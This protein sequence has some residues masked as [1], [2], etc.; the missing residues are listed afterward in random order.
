MA[1]PQHPE[2]W[3]LWHPS[4]GVLFAPTA[5]PAL[6]TPLN[7]ARFLHGSTPDLLGSQPLSETENNV[8]NASQESGRNSAP[9]SLDPASER[10][11]DDA[12]IDPAGAKAAEAQDDKDVTSKGEGEDGP[13]E[14]APE[15]ED[16][17]PSALPVSN[18]SFKMTDDTFR[19]A[20]LAKPG[21]PESYWS[22]TL[23]RGPGD[24]G[25]E[26]KKVTVHYCRS[27]AT[28]EKVCKLFLD[29][30]VLG[31][32]L[33]W[34]PNALK[35]QGARK[36]VS[37]VQIASP[38]RIALFHLAVYPKTD[39]LVAP[40]LKKILE[41]NSITK[42]GVWIKGDCTRLRNFLGIKPAGIF[43]LSHLYKVVK[44]SQP[45]GDTSLVNSTLR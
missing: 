1:S 17:T 10:T 9:P 45:G 42:T 28:T 12:G 44:H 26:D 18:L 35:H 16:D 41:D 23:Y 40:T 38:S 20:Q 34:S 22:Y 29:E 32:D 39:D 15:E 31:L 14:E 4:H 36:N 24:D 43:E 3:R 25:T 21:N 30:K 2:K 19:A 33:E 7:T 5:R 37:L 11:A 6:S 13:E 27:L 8:I